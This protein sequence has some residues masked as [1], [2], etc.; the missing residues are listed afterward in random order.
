MLV[1]DG[2]SVGYGEV[3]NVPASFIQQTIKFACLF[4]YPSCYLLT[5]R[6]QQSILHKRPNQQPPS[7]NCP[8]NK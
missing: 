7:D 8:S 2:V 6:P 4:T 3:D 5:L 1:T